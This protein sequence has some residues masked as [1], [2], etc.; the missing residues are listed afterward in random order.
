VRARVPPPPHLFRSPRPLPRLDLVVAP[1]PSLVVSPATAMRRGAALL[2][3]A[4]FAVVAVAKV[5]RV[6]VHPP[7]YSSWPAGWFINCAAAQAFC[8]MYVL[9]AGGIWMVLKLPTGPA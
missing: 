7:A 8:G 1:R 2:L 5:S 3:V 6:C 9:S 4:V